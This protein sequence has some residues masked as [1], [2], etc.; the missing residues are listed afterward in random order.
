MYGLKELVE[1]EQGLD[2]SCMDEDAGI[3]FACLDSFECFVRHFWNMVPGTE[4]LLWNWH[5]SVICSEAEQIAKGLFQNK[6]RENDI[7]VNISPG[8]TKST[9]VSILFPA[10]IWANMPHARILS[11][12]HTD[13]L[14]TDL[15]NKSRQVIKSPE[16]RE[17]FPEV[18]IRADQDSKSYYA[19][20]A[21][22]D[23]YTCTVAGKSPM[24]FHA[25][26]I[27]CDDPI[28]PKKAVSE[29]E[30]KTAKDFFD[31]V[32]PSRKVNKEVAVTFL[33]MQRLH[34]GDPTGH[35]LSKSR[36][37]GA[38]PIKHFKLPAELPKLEDGTYDESVVSP[39]ELARH[40]IDFNEDANAYP[41]GLMD[42]V[43]LSRKV[44]NERRLETY[45]FSGQYMQWPVPLGGGMFK[46]TYFSKRTK[47]APYDCE[48]VLYVDRASTQDG[49]CYTAGVCMARSKD[50]RFFI[51]YVMHGQWEPYERNQRIKAAAIKLRSR[52]G[53]RYEPEIQI[54][55]EGGASGK[56]D[57]L[58]IARELVGFRVR[59]HNIVG[60]G[61]K[62]HRAEPW[63]SQ[64]AAGNVWIVDNGESEGTGVCDWDI[65][66]YVHEHILFP[67]GTYKDQVDASCLV[68]GTL[69][70]TFEGLVPIEHVRTGDWVLTRS[71]WRK[72]Q[73]SGQTGIALNLVEVVFTNG[74]IIRGTFDHPVLT[75]RRG[76]V[77]LGELQSSD[78]V[79]ISTPEGSIQSWRSG[80]STN[81][82]KW[83]SK[84]SPIGGGC[85]MVD[86]ILVKGVKNLCTGQF[87]SRFTEAFPRSMTF[88]TRT[89]ISLTTRSI[90]LNVSPKRNID[91]HIAM[92]TERSNNS[93]IWKRFDPHQQNGIVRLRE[94]NGTNSMGRIVGRTEHTNRTS[95]FSVELILNLGRMNPLGIVPVSATIECDSGKDVEKYTRKNANGVGGTL[96]RASP[97][98][99]FVES[100][101]QLS[102]GVP[103]YNLEVDGQPEFFAN[104]V[105][106][107]NSGGLIVMSSRTQSRGVQIFSSRSNRNKDLRI[108]FGDFK[109]LENSQIDDPCLLFLLEEPL[110]TGREVSGEPKH[111]LS[112]LI[113]TLTLNFADIAPA[114]YQD[115]WDKPLAAYGKV[116][117]EVMLT[118]D[119]V[120]K[121]WA[122]ITKNR[123]VPYQ[124]L[125]LIDDG[126]RKAQSFALAICDI[127]GK[128]P[129]SAVFNLC[130]PDSKVGGPASNR[131]LYDLVKLGRSL[132]V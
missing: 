7:I 48:R 97:V 87:G 69:I 109:S 27:I 108:F 68:A 31:N 132:V 25:H 62:E 130:Q 111:L 65:E 33:I 94:G 114:D 26:V 21:G 38:A 53:P 13:D 127:F 86:T 20:T 11:A 125:V 16:Y 122:F 28:D 106:V 5:M 45:A 117:E 57:F 103:V 124:S 96:R 118:R 101:A 131:H 51:E 75:L 74:S 42:P 76:F 126:S 59:E 93:V 22:G 110:I 15:A 112:G 67:K 84:E 60:M 129:D 3:R 128:K 36:R 95:A 73:W 56:G 98:S 121:L 120:K 43:R 71:G 64:L 46:V 113:G 50:G 8:T 119:D 70:E 72:I 39:F 37:E 30:L 34:E 102:H 23:R 10:W 85:P 14:V 82:R 89:T 18:V 58:D 77:K 54:E 91:R 1:D 78:V 2:I 19:N 115:V 6:P 52:F 4:P 92:L 116:P 40:Y 41:D 63:S 12:S 61:K 90:I 55:R 123:E 83:C 99:D 66:S 104:G 17:M 81:T 9:L 100:L 105:L 47:A 80:T 32:L 107:H 49:G 24:G 29:V 88:I 35:L 44:L 79:L